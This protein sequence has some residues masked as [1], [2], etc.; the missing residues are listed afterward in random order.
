MIIPNQSNL[1]VHF[2]GVETLSHFA[3]VNAA[4]IQYSLFTVFPFILAKIK[5]GGSPTF[6]NIPEII[7]NNSRHTIMDSGLFSLMFGSYKGKKDRTFIEKWMNLIID[8]VNITGY[9]GTCVEVD[10]QKVLGVE[11]A[12]QFREYMKNHLSNRLINVFHMEDGQKGLDRLIEYSDYIALS[13]PELRLVGKKDYTYRLACYVKNKK[14]TIDIHLLG[15]TEN[16]LLEQCKFCSTSDSTSWL[17]PAKYGVIDIAGKKVRNKDIKKDIFI[18]QYKN[19]LENIFNKF[20]INIT[21]KSYLYS[22]ILIYQA[23]QLKIKYS[24]YAG[25]QD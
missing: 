5:N 20:Q 21:Q 24:K 6:T 14:P 23:E 1:K 10:C 8:F 18:E 4:D 19:K 16:K 15:C 25:S 9:K 13:I 11:E 17:A 2:A 3:C 12:W 7:N 22:S